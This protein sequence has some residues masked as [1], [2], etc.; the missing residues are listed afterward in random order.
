MSLVS[1][2]SLVSN[3]FLTYTKVIRSGILMRFSFYFGEL[4]EGD[5]KSS[6]Y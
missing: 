5:G 3:I 4:C 1:I 6:V 2:T